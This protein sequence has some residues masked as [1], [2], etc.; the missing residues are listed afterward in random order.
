MKSQFF[1][2]Q[3]PKHPL[4]GRVI[5]S[6]AELGEILAAVRSRPPFFVE[7]V[8]EHGRRGASSSV[9]QVVLRRISWPLRVTP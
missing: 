4:S 7:F 5:T 1:Y 3:D 8:G 6:S 2:R 9:L